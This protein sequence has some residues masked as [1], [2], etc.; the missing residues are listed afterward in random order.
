[1]KISNLTKDEQVLQIREDPELDSEEEIVT[2]L[3]S[4]LCL[5]YWRKSRTLHPR[6]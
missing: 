6:P 2:D 1:M 3:E 4:L 5:V